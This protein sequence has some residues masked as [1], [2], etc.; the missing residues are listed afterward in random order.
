[1]DSHKLLETMIQLLAKIED[2]S[3][4]L[5]QSQPEG[6]TQHADQTAGASADE[7]KGLV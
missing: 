5:K 3:V 7:A 4:L 6:H 2:P 1:M